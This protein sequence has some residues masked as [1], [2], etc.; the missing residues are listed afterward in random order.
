MN[1]PMNL[2]AFT[3]SNRNNNSGAIFAIRK[4]MFEIK[5]GM[6]LG[7]G[8]S[9]WFNVENVEELFKKVKDTKTTIVAL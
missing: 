8:V 3:L 6:A 1:S 7:L 4:P 2:A 5:E 9:L